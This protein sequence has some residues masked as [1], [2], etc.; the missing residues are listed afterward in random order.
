MTTESEKLL[1]TGHPSHVVNLPIYIVCG[2]TFF[3]VVPLLYGVWRWVE[4]RCRRYELTNQRLRII[5]GV[6]NRDED[7][8]EL[9]RVKD[10]ILSQPF[11]LRLFSLGNLTLHTSDRTTP[12]LTIPALTDPSAFRDLLRE[13][14]ERRRDEKRVREIDFE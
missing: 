10:I 2:I 9:Y 4:L 7:E 11:I 5:H 12:E 14:V 1:W 3:L 6:F 8:L 13:Q